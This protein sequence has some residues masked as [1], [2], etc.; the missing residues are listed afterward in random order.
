M[1]MSKKEFIDVVDSE[2]NTALA[3]PTIKKRIEA[4]WFVL[5]TFMLITIVMTSIEMLWFYTPASM[6]VKFFVTLLAGIVIYDVA[7]NFIYVRFIM[8]KH[9]EE[10]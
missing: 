5:E 6:L 3:K 7:K 1:V 4:I 2:V 10:A 9:T 8:L